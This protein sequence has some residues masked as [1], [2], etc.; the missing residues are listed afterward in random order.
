MGRFWIVPLL[1]S[2]SVIG[3]K[4]TNKVKQAWKNTEVY[5]T[6]AIQSNDVLKGALDTKWKRR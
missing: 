5:E 4:K 6:R 1:H 2:V 3:E